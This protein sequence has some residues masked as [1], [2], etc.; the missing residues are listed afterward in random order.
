MSAEVPPDTSS[1][2]PPA[3]MARA[4]DNA[5]P[6]DATA[7][8]MQTVSTADVS[9]PPTRIRGWHQSL[10]VILVFLIFGYALLIPIV[11]DLV[12]P[13]EQKL[14]LRM[15]RMPLGQAIEVN[16]M[17]AIA[18]LW[19]LSLGGTV[20]SFLNVVAYRMPRNKSVVFNPSRCPKCN[21]NI[22][23]WD[24]LPIFGWL[25]L[26]GK[27]RS[28]RN[29]ISPQ[30]PIVEAIVAGL[31]LLVFAFELVSGGMNL[32][33]QI[34]VIR[35]GIVWI[36]FELQWDLIASYFYHCILLSLVFSWMLIDFQRLSVTRLAIVV[37]AAILFLPIVVKPELLP[38]PTVLADSLER[39]ALGDSVLSSLTGGAIGM[40][41]G[42][43]LAGLY[44]NR[45]E[46]RSESASNLLE[47][48]GGLVASV[49]ESVSTSAIEN[50]RSNQVSQ[51]SSVESVEPLSHRVRDFLDF[52]SVASR[53]GVTS[54]LLFIG[55]A[56]GWQAVLQI[57]GLALGL[58]I[59]TLGV[60]QLF[61][62]RLPLSVF[63]FLG[64]LIHLANWSWI[65]QVCKTCWPGA[66]F[67][68]ISSV[69][70]LIS[71][72]VLM[73]VNRLGRQPIR[74]YQSALQ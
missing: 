45:R 30:Y 60:M 52:P 39:P 59:L 6:R 14:P 37:G 9:P 20:G 63:L 73:L 7:L 47:A 28:C 35:S 50:E 69:V 72:S 65:Y 64:L 1:E 24:N 66:E 16:A 56:F 4:G 68:P 40:L 71:L 44:S 31:F 74:K 13:A 15:D 3:G 43:L 19:I 58:R 53:K 12:E 18:V 61:K 55:L 36:L 33:N 27:C 54:I 8:D 42:A 5:D 67:Q 62:F 2:L 38:V 49:S 26:E 32:P 57:V 11:Q 29:P 23:P 25:K 22:R 34:P 70:F 46:I 41:I 51:E 48:D 17:K 10:V 21:S